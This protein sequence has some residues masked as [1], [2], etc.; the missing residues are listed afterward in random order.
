MNNKKAYIIRGSVIEE[1]SRKE[2]IE[3]ITISKERAEKIKKDLNNSLVK[4][5]EKGKDVF[6][7]Y[8]KDKNNKV[9][10]DEMEFY[11]EKMNEEEFEKFCIY[12]YGTKMPFKIEVL[13][14]V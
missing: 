11:T 9:P 5:I 2:W 3:K 6:D 10:W 7:L 1:G 14:L 12:R 13:D 8:L 4:K